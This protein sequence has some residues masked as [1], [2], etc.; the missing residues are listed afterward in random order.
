MLILNVIFYYYLY[1]YSIEVQVP[2]SRVLIVHKSH[3]PSTG[4]DLLQR[5]FHLITTRY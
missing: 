5:L 3:V 1:L 4:T 2:A